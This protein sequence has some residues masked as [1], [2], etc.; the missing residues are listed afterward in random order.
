M[1]QA[2]SPMAIGVTELISAGSDIGHLT[3][4]GR[5][6]ENK[7]CFRESGSE[8]GQ[9]GSEAGVIRSHRCVRLVFEGAQDFLS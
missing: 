2:G 6:G 3:V 9:E 1:R 5:K 8:S 7:V 4:I